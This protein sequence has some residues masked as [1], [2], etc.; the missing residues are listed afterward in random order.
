MYRIRRIR[1][2]VV[3]IKQ[4]QFFGHEKACI[5]QI[6]IIIT[7]LE[8]TLLDGLIKPKYCGAFREVLDAYSQ[9]L[10]RIDLSKIISYAQQTNDAVC[11]RLGYILS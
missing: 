6:S 9:A 8:R 3:R 7:D 1:Y 4:D 11:K 10:D 2:R 5:G